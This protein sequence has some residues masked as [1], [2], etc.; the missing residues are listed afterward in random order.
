MFCTR[1]FFSVSSNAITTDVV[2]A[3]ATAAH[4][5]RINASTQC[6]PEKTCDTHVFVQEFVF[7]FEIKICSEKTKI[8]H[9]DQHTKI[10]TQM[11][12]ISWGLIY[13]Y[14]PII[15]YRSKEWP[16]FLW[17]NKFIRS[18]NQIDGA[19]EVLFYNLHQ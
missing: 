14:E 19:P 15:W 1:F 6:N 5:N 17:I 9:F 12:L 16:F 13:S 7:S 8:N 4:L 10:H 18:F 3:A 11:R 2:T